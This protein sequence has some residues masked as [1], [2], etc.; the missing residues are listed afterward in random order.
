MANLK[1]DELPISG[2]GS[3]D[4]ELLR[5]KYT[6]RQRLFWNQENQSGR[7]WDRKELTYKSPNLQLDPRV[8]YRTAGPNAYEDFLKTGIVRGTWQD[9]DGSHAKLFMSQGAPLWSYGENA[10]EKGQNAYLFAT[11]G[12]DWG[13]RDSDVKLTPHDVEQLDLKQ[14]ELTTAFTKEEHKQIDALRKS[15]RDLRDKAI[16]DEK[17]T[18]LIV[19]SH[20]DENID[21]LL[22]KHEGIIDRISS[23]MR[24]VRKLR[25]SKRINDSHPMSAWQDILEGK[26]S[27]V[28]A[29]GNPR[30]YQLQAGGPLK[31]KRYAGAIQLPEEDVSTHSID[32]TNLGKS[33]SFLKPSVSGLWGGENIY[34]FGN[35]L[36]QLQ[37]LHKT[38][39]SDEAYKLIN[40]PTAT[41]NP[42]LQS[43]GWNKD[44]STVSFNNPTTQHPN[45]DLFNSSGE[46]PNFSTKPMLDSY[47]DYVHPTI[48]PD[49]V[50]LGASDDNSP[51]WIGAENIQKF[52]NRS[53]TNDVVWNNGNPFP[54]LQ[55]NFLTHGTQGAMHTERVPRSEVVASNGKTWDSGLSIDE[56]INEGVPLGE[57]GLPRRWG[58]A[59]NSINANTRPMAVFRINP[60]HPDGI[61]LIHEF[62]NET[63]PDGTQPIPVKPPSPTA[64]VDS[65]KRFLDEVYPTLKGVDMPAEMRARLLAGE[66]VKDLQGMISAGSSVQG[67]WHNMGGIKDPNSFYGLQNV[68]NESTRGNPS[69]GRK[70]FVDMNLLTQPLQRH[71]QSFANVAKG[72]TEKDEFLAM[73]QKGLSNP[74]HARNFATNYTRNPALRGAVNA[75]MG[76]SA[77]KFLGKVGAVAGIVTAPS[78]AVE[79]RDRI[80]ADWATNNR[81]YPNLV[82]NFGMRAQAGIEN[83]LAV[84]TMGISDEYLHPEWREPM[85]PVQRGYYSDNGQ[86]VPN[87]VPNLQSTLLSPK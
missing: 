17:K 58:F 66:P 85:E 27:G 23:S 78:S 77:I 22:R 72:V 44:V 11:L 69:Y 5:D 21:Y 16:L 45:S 70:G 68:V 82:Q 56:D 67:L 40:G 43:G 33:L 86:R 42:F 83:A 64:I 55:T 30:A 41:R 50:R 57:D 31:P 15:I 14:F 79:R 2:E 37:S 62:N 12:E 46:N 87:W 13:N 49:L 81:G 47:Y 59:A 48:T 73:M 76:A 26:H 18:G 32:S 80:F 28:N 75:E 20:T 4:T 84:G 38:D 8:Q 34:A 52:L 7:K 63:L 36:K 61:E 35:Y 74:D 9:N 65:A 10:L 24:D 60:D 3:I 71:A 39:I 1:P 25:D 19:E 29:T 54:L 51:S 53:L 6:G